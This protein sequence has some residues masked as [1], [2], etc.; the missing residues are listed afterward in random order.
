VTVEGEALGKPGTPEV[1][2][3][4]LRRLR[5][6]RHKVRTALALITAEHEVTRQVVAPLTMRDYSDG[7]IDHYVATGEPLDCAGAYDIHRLGGALIASVEGCFSC[8]VGLPIVETARL[9]RAGGVDVPGD[10][11]DVCGRLYRRPCLAA[12]PATA[13]RCQSF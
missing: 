6:R 3:Q 12:A 10:P 8:I 1:A 2:R 7:E 11:A 5:G 9:L 13:G 4:M